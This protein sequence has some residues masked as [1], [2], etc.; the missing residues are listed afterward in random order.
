M[1]E[2]VLISNRKDK[3]QNMMKNRLFAAI[4]ALTWA[5]TTSAWGLDDTENAYPDDSI[6]M[7]IMGRD[8]WQPVQMQALGYGSVKLDRDESIQRLREGAVFLQAAAELDLHNADAW[9][10]LARIYM[11]EATSDPGRATEAVEQYLTLEPEDASILLDWMNY[12]VNLLEDREKREFFLKQNLYIFQEHPRVYSAAELLLANFAEQKGLTDEARQWAGLAANAYQYNINALA[13]WVSYGPAQPKPET[14]EGLTEEQI[15]NYNVQLQNQYYLHI[16]R[17]WRL[18]LRNN[19]YDLNATLSLINVLENLGE[20][21]LAQDYYP[22]ALKLMGDDPAAGQLRRNRLIGA[23]SGKQYNTVIELAEAARHDDPDHPVVNALIA[24][25]YDQL[26]LSTDA[27]NIRRRIANR[28]TEV[29]Q[30]TDNPPADLLAQAGWFFAFAQKDPALALEYT[31]AAFQLEPEQQMFKS[32][33][34]YSLALN[35][36]YTEA[37][38]TLNGVPENDNTAALAWSMILRKKGE[39]E[40]ALAKLTNAFAG[41]LHE[42]IQAAI[43][44]L[45][46]ILQI[47]SETEDNA[48]APVTFIQTQFNAEFDNKDMALVDTPAD[49][50]QCGLKLTKDIFYFDDPIKVQVYLTNIG[51]SNSTLIIGP[52]GVVRGDV[53]ITAQVLPISGST[54][55]KNQPLETA[56]NQQVFILSNLNLVSRAVLKAGRSNTSTEYLNKGQ[57]RQLLVNHPQRTYQI[58]FQAYLDPL[59]TADGQLTSGIPDLH[60]QPITVTRKAFE[61]NAKRINMQM[62]L[63]R[64]GS[65]NERIRAA[66]LLGGLLRE[67]TLAHQGKLRYR[68]LEIDAPALQDALAENLKHDDARVRGWSAWALCQATPGPTSTAWTRLPELLSDANWFT[69]LLTAEA[70]RSSADLQEFFDWAAATENN[71]LLQRYITL[72]NNQPWKIIEM[73]V[74]IP[75]S[76]APEEQNTEEKSF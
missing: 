22:H 48:V 43:D 21:Q 30:E 71:P 42:E 25:A 26:G 9:H 54:A 51:P 1:I 66:S 17:R 47:E 69:R 57:L 19:P 45:N 63:L 64:T 36:Q 70:L 6:E 14:L 53:L 7:L 5:F 10:D 28:L 34:A 4:L 75:E 67:N 3:D 58:T 73:P 13:Q 11:F 65:A 2:T 20:Y 76:P 16:A 27:Q 59:V 52:Q 15:A 41:M 50:L 55:P 56:Q 62:R 31:Q 18:Q 68:V 40:N 49:F 33:Y 74:E 44:Q 37:E 60:P 38:N 72:R 32:L 23:W 12:R 8:A 61:P 35:G 24:K 39:N 46:T 29:I